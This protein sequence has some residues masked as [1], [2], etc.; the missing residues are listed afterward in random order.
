MA[1]LDIAEVLFYSGVI[2]VVGGLLNGE[3]LGFYV[4]F[5][6]TG[7][8]CLVSGLALRFLSLGSDSFA[9]VLVTLGIGQ[10]IYLMF[11]G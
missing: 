2:G 4:A 11:R 7:G 9:F 1:K 6:I 3:R 10:I 8:L 5:G